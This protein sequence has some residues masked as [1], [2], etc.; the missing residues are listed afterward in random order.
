MLD[1][2][3][4]AFFFLQP[5]ARLLVYSI[6]LSMSSTAVSSHTTTYLRQTF[7]ARLCHDFAGWVSAVSSFLVLHTTLTHIL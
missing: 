6:R 3:C 1:L 2:A 7:S 5:L 4:I